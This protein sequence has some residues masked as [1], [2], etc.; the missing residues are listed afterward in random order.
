[1]KKKQ[2][3]TEK[4]YWEKVNDTILV[5]GVG[6][7]LQG[8]KDMKDGEGL[9]AIITSPDPDLARERQDKALNSLGLYRFAIP[10]DGNCL[11]RA[12]ASQLKFGQES[13]HPLL[14]QAAVGWMHE[15]AEDLIGCGLLDSKD[16]IKETERLG[17]WPGQAAVVA[18]ANIFAI[19]IVVIQGGDKGFLDIQH[20]SPFETPAEDEEQTSIILAYLYHGH[21]DAVVDTPDLPNPDYEKWLKLVEMGAKVHG[22]DAYMPYVKHRLYDTLKGPKYIEMPPSYPGTCIAAES[23]PP[24]REATSQARNFDTSPKKATDHSAEEVRLPGPVTIQPKDLPQPTKTNKDP[25]KTESGDAESKAVPSSPKIQPKGALAQYREKQA[26]RRSSQERDILDEV[27][28]KLKIK[29]ML[30]E[31]KMVSGVGASGEDKAKT[32]ATDTVA[33][34]T[35]PASAAS[36]DAGAVK[37]APA[38]PASDTGD[39]AN[40][41]AST[42]DAE[43]ASPAAAAVA[44]GP[45]AVK[46]APA[47]A[48]SGTG[49][50]SLAAETQSV[51]LGVNPQL[52]TSQSPANEAQPMWRV[53]PIKFSGS[54]RKGRLPAALSLHRISLHRSYP[55][56]LLQALGKEPYNLPANGF[57]STQSLTQEGHANG[58]K[59]QQNG[60][61]GAS[62]KLDANRKENVHHNPTTQPNIKSNPDPNKL[63]NGQ[64]KIHD[65]SSH[66][67]QQIKVQHAQTQQTAASTGHV[68]GSSVQNYTNPKSQAYTG[69]GNPATVVTVQSEPVVGER[70]QSQPLHAR[71]QSLPINP[72][73]R[74]VPAAYSSSEQ[75]HAQSSTRSQQSQGKV[76]N[77]PIRVEHST[78]SNP[79]SFNPHGVG[80]NPYNAPTNP[81][82]ASG[83]PHGAGSHSY[84]SVNTAHGGRSQPFSAGTNPHG[85]NTNPHGMYNSHSSSTTYQSPGTPRSRPEPVSVFTQRFQQ[86]PQL[87][88]PQT[89]RTTHG[90]PGVR[91]TS[92]IEQ[93]SETMSQKMSDMADQMY[94]MTGSRPSSAAPHHQRYHSAPST[95]PYQSPASHERS[96]YHQRYHSTP[97]STPQHEPPSYQSVSRQS[98]QP[99]S[100]Y[101][102]SEYHRYTPGASTPQFTVT[103]N[104]GHMPGTPR[105]RRRH[106]SECSQT[107]TNENSEDRF[108]ASKKWIEHQAWKQALRSGSNTPTTPRRN[109]GPIRI[110][111]DSSPT[112]PTPQVRVD[113]HRSHTVS[114]SRDTHDGRHHRSRLAMSPSRHLSWEEDKEG[115]RVPI[116]VS[117]TPEYRR[118]PIPRSVPIHVEP[119]AR[120]SSEGSSSGLGFGRRGQAGG[121]R[122]PFQAKSEKPSNWFED[123]ERDVK[124]FLSP[125][126]PSRHNFDAW[127]R[128][129][130]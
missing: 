40:A 9:R 28:E 38:A 109:S 130:W 111:T 98:S 16:E 58:D 101:T 105:R 55:P 91:R 6:I 7:Y 80:T 10:G 53:I 20:I 48:A 51:N 92:N 65:T 43:K 97:M 14:R 99:T 26:A 11:F 113:Y 39:K 70:K 27:D 66:S 33:A 76:H 95:E 123:I 77:I 127:F 114:P 96:H 45:G 2:Y 84:S 75:Y 30:G 8:A 60:S 122:Q 72:N 125:D 50:G 24:P 78:A 82:S 129:D 118:R 93:M 62:K 25:P 15:H 56:T 57:G 108:V 68:H 90:S 63:A 46:A 59:T 49:S 81:Y 88:S 116:R 115:R 12:V 73:H 1:M 126:G 44:G 103:T 41:A 32:G 18:L 47:A 83:N 29:P 3:M 121:V 5:T 34:K 94:S 36:S 112:S 67:S 86:E 106:S 4:T 31:L 102:H 107:S 120:R 117:S 79:H 110:M 54:L 42:K 128:R 23:A 52:A 17:A 85:A 21:Y 13:Y 22:Q 37:A 104:T 35:A 74:H 19:N 69:S 119:E 89:S 71:P 87:Y 64:T 61:P 124:Q 100:P